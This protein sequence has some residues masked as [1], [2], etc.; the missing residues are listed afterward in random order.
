M[1]GFQRSRFELTLGGAKLRLGHETKIMGVLNVTPNSFSDGGCF[2]DPALAEIQAVRMEEEGAQLL[3]VGGES[4]KPG[5][6][7]VS[8]K[9][10][11]RR[12]RPVLKR[13]SRKIKIPV[14]VD[15]YKYEVAR[16][17]LD[18]GASM[19]NDIY[20][21][22][23]NAR[24]A[25]LI[26]RHKAGVVLMHMRGNPETMQNKIQY[27]NLLMEI[28]AYLKKAVRFALDAGIAARSIVI[29]PGFG[30][31]KTLEQNLKILSHLDFFEKLKCPILVGLSRKSFI[32]NLLAAPVSGRLYGSLGAAAVAIQ[33]GAHILRVHEVLPHRQMALLIDRTKFVDFSREEVTC[34]A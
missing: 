15:T 11:I 16:M 32:G 1:S 19:V 22:R 9:E 3:D 24:L 25:R 34:A 2:M 28:S 30:F 31:G 10:E 8:A 6:K 5:S 33:K 23:G 26:A 7:P 4:S 18:E 14:S 21:L 29:D 27:E 13:L 17:A 12:L 20:A